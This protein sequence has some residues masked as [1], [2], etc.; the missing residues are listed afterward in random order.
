MS[1]LDKQCST[2][3]KV[4][5]VKGSPGLRHHNLAMCHPTTARRSV[6]N[7]RTTQHSAAA[8][9]ESLQGSVQVLPEIPAGDWSTG[10]GEALRQNTRPLVC[11][12]S[13]AVHQTQMSTGTSV[14]KHPLTG[15]HP[16]TAKN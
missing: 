14:Q 16:Q 9:T 11:A 10:V 7:Q 8:Q 12:D 1:N 6:T 3:T 2:I 13:R 15:Q 5:K 4:F